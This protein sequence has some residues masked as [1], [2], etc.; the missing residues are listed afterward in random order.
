[1]DGQ[2]SDG[3]GPDYF[4]FVLAVRDDAGARRTRP[5]PAPSPSVSR[6]KRRTG[7][8]TDSGVATHMRA[9]RWTKIGG[10]ALA[11]WLVGLLLIFVL[12]LAM[13]RQTLAA[14]GRFDGKDRARLRAN[15]RGGFG[16]L[17]AR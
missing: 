12:G 11:L 14:V 3:P 16:R 8:A 17:T 13:S 7:Y 1:M 5:C 15:R 2:P 10:V 4:R 6:L 9:M